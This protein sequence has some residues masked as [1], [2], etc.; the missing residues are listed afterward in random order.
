MQYTFS[1]QAL[2]HSAYFTGPDSRFLQ[3]QTHRHTDWY[4]TN[5]AAHIAAH[6]T[7]NTESKRIKMK[8]VA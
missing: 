5:G 2:C 4:E 6:I 8:A 3:R 1:K 7:R